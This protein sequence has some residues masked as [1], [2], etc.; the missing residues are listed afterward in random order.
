MALNAVKDVERK[1]KVSTPEGELNRDH[2]CQIQNPGKDEILKQF[3]HLQPPGRRDSIPACPIQNLGKDEILKQFERLLPGR[4]DSIPAYQIQNLG[5][6]EILKQSER[7][8]PGRRDSIPAI[9]KS[10]H[11]Q[12]TAPEMV[13]EDATLP[14]L[15]LESRHPVPTRQGL[16]EIQV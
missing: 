13:K 16:D 6:D 12:W 1:M 8:L 15:A 11:L 4:G 7:L 3:E 2:A 10:T 14:I 9:A 5:K